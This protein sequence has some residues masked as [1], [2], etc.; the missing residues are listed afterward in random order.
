MSRIMGLVFQEGSPEGFRDVTQQ[1]HIN[2]KIEIMIISQTLFK[3][4]E[5]GYGHS[6]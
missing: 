3:L 1:P 5:H 2:L 4:S 6:H